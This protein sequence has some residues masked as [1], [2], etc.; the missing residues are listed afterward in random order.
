MDGQTS[1][2]LLAG[3]DGLLAVCS[4]Y[5]GETMT[6]TRIVMANQPIYVPSV[7]MANTTPQAHLAVMLTNRFP[8]DAG[9]GRVVLSNGQKVPLDFAKG[10]ASAWFDRADGVQADHLEVDLTSGGHTDFPSPL[11]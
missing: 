3:A 11:R 1:V 5:R 8:E 4:V 6:Q 2:P 7:G 10:Y 9:G